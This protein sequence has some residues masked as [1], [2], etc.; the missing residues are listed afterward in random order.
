MSAKNDQRTSGDRPLNNPDDDELGY[1]PFA[2]HLAQQ[3]LTTAAPEGFVIALN[4]PWGSGKTSLLNMVRFFLS[5]RK[6]DEQPISIQ[7]NPCGLPAKRTSPA[8]SSRPFNPLSRGR[9]RKSVYGSYSTA[10]AKW[11]RTSRSG[12]PLM[13]DVRSS[14]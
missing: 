1:A 4:G 13:W 3:I 9:G 11:Y 2:S 8:T 6:P 10:S 5:E 12:R 14:G 7:F